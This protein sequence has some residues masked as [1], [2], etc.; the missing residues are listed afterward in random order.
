[1]YRDPGLHDIPVESGV[2]AERSIYKTLDGKQYNRGVHLHK[3]TY[4]ALIRIACTGF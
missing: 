1:M 2:I 4:E 3:L